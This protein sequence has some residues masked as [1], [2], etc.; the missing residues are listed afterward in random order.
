M[1]DWLG[2]LAKRLQPMLSPAPS[3]MHWEVNV[4]RDNNLDDTAYVTLHATWRLVPTI[5]TEED[6]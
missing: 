5:E 2:D 3:G 6:Q 1:S 4:W